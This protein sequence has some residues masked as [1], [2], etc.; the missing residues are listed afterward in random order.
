MKQANK[1]TADPEWW[2]RLF[3]GNWARIYSFKS[4]EAPREARV[5]SRLL[6][7]PPASKILDLCC[8]DGRIAVPLARLGYEITGLD[9][10][11]TLLDKAKR[12]ALRAKVGIK[13]VQRDMREIGIASDFD[14]VINIS[15][16]FGYFQSEE[17]DLEVIQSVR[18]ALRPHGKLVIDLENMYFLARVAQEHRSEPIYQPIDNFRG[19]VEEIDHFDPIS[20]RV[21]INLRLWTAGGRLVKEGTACYRAYSLLELRKMLETTGFFIQGVYG[22]LTSLRNYDVDS[23]RMIVLCSRST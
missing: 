4:R 7:L 1:S 3:D 6:D 17:D 20:Q 12:R 18:N 19:W 11:Q 14:G 10:S 15:S 13:W 8:G 2:Q 5:I 23:P 21:Q 16:S 22:D 9:L